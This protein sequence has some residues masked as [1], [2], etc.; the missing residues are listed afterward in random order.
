MPYSG[1]VNPKPI[2]SIFT[3]LK[4]SVGWIIFGLIFT[5]IIRSTHQYSYLCHIS[6]IIALSLISPCPQAAPWTAQAHSCFGDCTGCSLCQKCSCICSSSLSFFTCFS[7]K[8][9]TI[10]FQQGLSRLPYSN[11]MF[12]HPALLIPL[13]AVIYFFSYFFIE[14]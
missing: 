4:F 8:K 11:T 12:S 13:T 10:A 7:S 9:K 6:A 14:I 3:F 2:L 1:E 5:V